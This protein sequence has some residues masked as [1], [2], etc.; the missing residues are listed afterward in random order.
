MSGERSTPL[1]KMQGTSD[2]AWLDWDGRIHPVEINRPIRPKISPM[3]TGFFPEKYQLSSAPPFR[4]VQHIPLS[5]LTVT[6]NLT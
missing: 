3:Y 5:K 1:V 2:K 4:P 6:T